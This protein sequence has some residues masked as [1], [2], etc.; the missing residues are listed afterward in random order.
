[1]Q[2]AL[3]IAEK[4]S[5]KR[6]IEA[7]YN[8]NRNKIP[9]EIDFVSQSGHLITLMTPTELD[10]TYKN[11]N[12]DDLPILPSKLS[13]YKYKV[14]PDK[15]NCKA[16]LYTDIERR[17]KSGNYDFVIHAGDP[18][19]EG[20]LLVNI[21]LDRIGCKLPIKRFWSNDL[22]E[23]KILDALNHMEDDRHTPKLCNLYDAAL[24]RQ[25]EDYLYGMN[26]SRAATLKLN[27]RT[28]VG[29]VKTTVLNMVVARENEIRNFKPKTVFGVKVTYVNN[30]DSF[31]CEYAKNIDKEKK[32][33]EG[34]DEKDETSGIIYFETKAEADALIGKLEDKGTVISV[35][36]KSTKQ[37]APK[38]YK[39]ATLQI[40]ADKLGYNADITLKIVQSLYE[41]KYL[42]YPRT[43]CEHISSNEDLGQLLNSAASIPEL[44][45]YIS[46]INRGDIIK[47]KRTKSYVNDIELEKH[48]HS[49][50]IPTTNKPNYA[51][52]SDDEKIIYDLVCRRF[53]AIFLP[54]IL[55]DKTTIITDINGNSFRSTGKILKDPGFSVIFNVSFK[56]VEIPKVNEGDILDVK[57]T[58]ITEKTSVCP[59]RFTSG[60]LIQAMENPVKYLNDESLKRLGKKLTI[61]TS[62]TRANIISTLLE[63]DFYLKNIRDKKVEYIAPTNV[64]EY[65]INNLHTLNLCKVD[66]SGQMEEKLEM[67]R[68]GVI[69]KE[70]AEREVE[71][72]VIEMIIEIKKLS[73]VGVPPVPKKSRNVSKK[74]LKKDIET[75]LS[76]PFAEKDSAKSLGARWDRDKKKWYVPKGVNPSPFKKWVISFEEASAKNRDIKKIEAE[77]YLNVPYADK[78][79]IKSIGGR[80]DNDRK[81]WYVPRGTDITPFK[82]WITATIKPILPR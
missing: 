34:K 9:M 22:T 17:I 21:V 44:V 25:H 39:L 11:W 78:D 35:E 30:L 24:T 32:D 10:I 1:M 80:W 46:K 3:L 52:L 37:Y 15:E 63:S 69:K 82:N 28:A 49:A 26:G 7:V 54:P 48:G 42:S 76:V 31:L 50:L 74:V 62:A 12:F 2:K 33:N 57:A 14:I 53:V 5:L 72:N 59:K 61:G 36:R 19:Q 70:T 6:E 20:E 55:Q 71:R 16:K 41:K 51:S 38:L 8:K 56:D 18:D 68:T 64:G 81:Q 4:P 47:I 27:I 29:R 77:S 75:Y 65:I 73:V 40:A 67:V 13:G 43:D 23:T 60:T 58:G 45:P 66:M 79:K